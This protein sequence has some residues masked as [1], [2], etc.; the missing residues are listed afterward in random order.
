MTLGENGKAAAAL[1][2]ALAANP[3]QAGRIR[4]EARILGVPG[5]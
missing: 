5:A 1:N 3:A 2:R 4:D